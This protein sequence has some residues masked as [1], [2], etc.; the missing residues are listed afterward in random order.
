MSWHSG[1][2]RLDYRFVTSDAF[3]KYEALENLSV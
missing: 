3:A 2:K 1:G